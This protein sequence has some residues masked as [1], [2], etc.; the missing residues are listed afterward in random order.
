MSW[1]KPLKRHRGEELGLITPMRR[2]GESQPSPG[3]R[4]DLF[5]LLAD[6]ASRKT[7]HEGEIQALL[8]AQERHREELE[9]AKLE[10]ARLQVGWRGVIYIGRGAT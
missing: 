4:P 6:R 2:M 9:E 5:E 7:E 8:R 10:S 1:H 3:P